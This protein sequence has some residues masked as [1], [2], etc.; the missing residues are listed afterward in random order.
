MWD[1]SSCVAL[2]DFHRG[3]SAFNRRRLAPIS[4]THDW[5]GDLREELAWRLREG[6]FLE[7]ERAHV[8]E[9]ADTAPTDRDAFMKWFEDLDQT[10]PG[11]HDSLFQW[12][13]DSAPRGALLWFLHQEVGGEAGF[14]DL[15]A[16]TQVKMPVI[17]KLE[18]ARN[19]WDEMGQGKRPGMHGPMLEVLSEE[20][21]VGEAEDS[22]PIVWESLALSNLMVG[23]ATNR[24]YAFQSVGALGAIEMTAPWRAERVNLALKRLGVRG[25]ARR[26]FALHSTLDVKHS[27][28]WNSEVIYTLAKDVDAQRAMAEGALMRLEA[29]RRCFEQYRA[30]LFETDILPLGLTG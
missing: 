29:G 7:R 23:L 4:K 25:E 8:R 18:L 17:A 24:R 11:Q 1:T 28:A 30:H 14:E 9:R 26:Y 5:R 16:M 27:K 6:E 15:V 13:A 3:L 2:T 19:Y 20:L 10:G 22:T 21:G 12:L